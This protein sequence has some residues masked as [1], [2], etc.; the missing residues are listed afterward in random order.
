MMKNI[1]KKNFDPVKK[2]RKHSTKSILNDLKKM[3]NI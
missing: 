2:I 1:I 3:M